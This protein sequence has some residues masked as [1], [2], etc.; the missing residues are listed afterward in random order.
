MEKIKRI[1]LICGKQLNKKQN[2]YCST[3]CSNKNKIPWNKGLT[4]EKDKRILLLSKKVSKTL[5]GKKR[6]KE[7]IK[8]QFITLRKNAKKR[9]YYASPKSRI[10]LSNALK[11]RKFT[12]EWRKK[13]SLAAKGR[14]SW[15]KGK[16]NCFSEDTRKKMSLAKKDKKLSL[17]LM[18]KFTMKGKKHSEKTKRKMRIIMIEKMLKN[19]NKYTPSYNKKSIPL[20]ISLNKDFSLEGI[21]AEN[22]REHLIKDIGYF[23]DYYEPNLNLVIEWNEEKHYELN[24]NTNRYV[25]NKKHKTRQ[26]EIKK[27]L[28]CKFIN[29]REKT[30]NKEKLYKKINNY[31]FDYHNAHILFFNNIE[32]KVA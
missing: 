14:K 12:K 9:G 8:K 5:T 20:F 22:P 17:K 6:S 15:N 27:Y 30:F 16:K 24:K 4:K 13:L 19:G 29:I 32:R 1:C 2:K 11:G 7:S 26:K 25:L 18:K 31:L 28:R 10:N 23:V 21:F 3:K